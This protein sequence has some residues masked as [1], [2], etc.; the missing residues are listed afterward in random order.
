MCWYVHRLATITRW[1]YDEILWNLPLSAGLQ[2][3][4][5]ELFKENIPR[6]YVSLTSE[7]DALS[8]IDKALNEISIR[9]HAV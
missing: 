9:Q 8:I 1:A 3:I 7:I 2:I 6:V 5:A 4:D